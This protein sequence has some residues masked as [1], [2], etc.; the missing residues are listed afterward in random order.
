MYIVCHR[1]GFLSMLG[2]SN[3][4]VLSCFAISD[5][6]EVQASSTTTYSRERRVVNHQATKRMRLRASMA[7]SVTPAQKENRCVMSIS[8]LPTRRIVVDSR[9]RS[10]ICR[11]RT[12]CIHPADLGVCKSMTYLALATPL[13]KSQCK[14]SLTSS[15][16]WCSW[17]PKCR[18]M[19][20]HQSR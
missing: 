4:V 8:A 15:P 13:G 20:P 9:M 18:S 17:Y 3:R 19:Q 11:N 10:K 14:A 1:S 5:K 2:P 7:A 12:L 16:N 6:N